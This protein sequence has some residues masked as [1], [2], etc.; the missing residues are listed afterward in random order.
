MKITIAVLGFALCPLLFAPGSVV[1]AQQATNQIRR[2][3]YLKAGGQFG[4][5]DESF[6]QGLRDLGYVEGKNILIERRGDLP[7]SEERLP[8]LAAELVRLNVDII[9][10]LDPPSARA[11]KKA[12]SSIPIVMRAYSDPV[13]DGLVAS[14]AHPGG[15]LTGVYSESDEL[16]PKRLELI[17]EVI[18]R[19][20]RVAVLQDRDFANT[21][22]AYRNLEIAAKTL[23][24]QL[25]ALDVRVA[26]DFEAAFHNAVRNRA[27]AVTTIRTP[28]IVSRRERIANLA[29][30]NK[31]PAIYDDREFVDAGGLM[32][33]GTNLQD[34]YKRA[35][36]FVDK[37]F[38]G[39]TPADLPV[40]QP[41]KFE[42]VINLKTAKQI[43]LT[44]PPNVLTR[45]D[46]V[47]R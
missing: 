43:G 17:K 36:T 45:A 27:Q 42:F 3:G 31:I 15:N 32:S 10:A 24:L 6:L 8:D 19:L 44:I 1:Q 4:A 16:L 28:L 21:A 2:I 33:Y 34:L 39:R 11:A 38:K 14:I 46:R 41:T 40:E 20:Y 26:A 18:P 30:I 47:I 35:A 25:Q 12:T 29:V 13:A 22:K 7:R 23:G 9:V 5:R 37:I